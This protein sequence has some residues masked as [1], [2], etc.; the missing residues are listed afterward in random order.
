MKLRFTPPNDGKIHIYCEFCR[1]EA[2]HEMGGKQNYR[3]RWCEQTSARALV[4]D[5]N[6][7]YWV[8]ADGEYCHVNSGVFLV[9]AEG[10]F[11]FFERVK[12][13]AGLTIPAGHVETKEDIDQAAARELFEEVSVLLQPKQL[14]YIA[15]ETIPNDKCHRGADVHRW[16][17][18]VAT[19]PQDATV[20]VGKQ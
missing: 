3:C 14:T 16:H 6:V 9:N 20:K 12:Y 18:F 17:M 13:P 10:K 2:I 4:I 15:E 8:E 7:R 11:L 19:L 1:R 5:P